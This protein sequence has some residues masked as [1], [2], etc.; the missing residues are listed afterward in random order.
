MATI[1]YDHLIDWRK[2]DTAIRNLGIDSEERQT[3]MTH[4]EHI[5]HM[6]VL[7]VIVSHLPREKHEEF[8]TRFHSAPHDVSHLHYIVSHTTTD[9]ESAI[10]NK[11]DDLI[12][13]IIGEL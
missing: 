7:M 11:A 13:E 6:H 10:R 2:L 1:F 3:V 9:V 8:I 12:Q 5:I 4:A